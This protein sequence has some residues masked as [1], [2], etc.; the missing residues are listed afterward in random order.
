[1]IWMNFSDQDASE[2]SAEITRRLR[3]AETEI[4]A[5]QIGLNISAAERLRE[6][7]L[8]GLLPGEDQTEILATIRVVS[9]LG[10]QTD[11]MV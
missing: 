8:L 6:I 9:E 2:I 5:A 3:K 7:R 10:Q 1:M 11:I 4:Q